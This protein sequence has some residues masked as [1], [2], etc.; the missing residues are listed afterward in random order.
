M[1]VLKVLLAVAAVLPMMSSCVSDG[2]YY[3]GFTNVDN[4]DRQPVYAN[5]PLG[6]I[7]FAS[8]GEWVM[9]QS[10][11]KDWC[12]V[13]TMHGRGSA[14]YSIPVF[15]KLNTT[16]TARIA[17]FRLRDAKEGDDAYVDFYLSQYAT[18]GDGSLGNAALVST[19]TGDDGSSIEIAYDTLCRPVTLVMEKNG[20]ELRK[21][22]LSYERTDSTIRIKSGSSVLVS[23]YNTGFIP[24]GRLCS[25]TDTVGYYNQVTMGPEDIAFN[26]EEH[27]RGGEYTAQALLLVGQNLTHPDV[28]HVADSLKYQHRYADGS[29]YT[30]ML[31][32]A[33]S[34]SSNRSQSVDVNQ[35]LLGVEEC[36]PYTLLS[37][38]PDAR[39]SKII[40]EAR[41]ADGKFTV[42]AELNADKSVSRLAVTGK[43]GTKVTYTFTYTS[44]P[45]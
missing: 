33:Y 8:Y 27:K 13:Q 12:T 35:L 36:N 24:A 16:G 9:S 5:T 30:E 40:S 23:K 45:Q 19:I 31:K 20:T 18:R 25:G 22:S 6:Y 21:L 11:G 43:Q 44:L 41:A 10:S 37:L 15:Y 7:A 29:K 39:N 3:A 1:K 4:N 28:E 17:N 26:V 34:E 14:I 42:E 32:L 2:D 38:F